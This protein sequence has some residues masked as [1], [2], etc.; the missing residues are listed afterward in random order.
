MRWWLGTV[1]LIACVATWV[2]VDTAAI[3]F[4]HGWA[5]GPLSDLLLPS[6]F[7]DPIVFIT[8]WLMALSPAMGFFAIFRRLSA[9]LSRY[10]L[11]SDKN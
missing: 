7:R 2:T 3:L 9:K 11:L 4:A 8:F 1:F 6:S 5:V 10:R